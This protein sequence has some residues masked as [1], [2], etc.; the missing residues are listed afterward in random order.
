MKV[1]FGRLSLAWIA[2]RTPRA[3]PR[4]VAM[5]LITLL[6]ACESPEEKEARHYERGVELYEEGQDEKAMVEFQNVLRLNPKNAEAMYYFGLI[7][8]R[9]GRLEPAF[10]AFQQAS[11]E[12]TDFMAAQVKL[13]EAALALEN[14]E[15]ALKAA[16]TIAKREPDNPDALAIRASLALRDD[17]TKNAL[18]FANAALSKVPTHLNGIAVL[19][20]VYERLGELERA[21]ALL[22]QGLAAHPQNVGLRLLKIGLLEKSGDVDGLDTTYREIFTLKPEDVEYRLLLAQFYLR[23]DDLARAEAILRQ[24]IDEGLLDDSV[25][26]ALID[27]VY[28]RR[29]F[30][31]AEAELRNLLERMPQNYQLQFRLADLYAT[32]GQPD[33]AEQT[34][35]AIIEKAEPGETINDARAAIARI[36]LAKDDS[37]G[38][39]N[40][41]EEA[42]AASPDHPG[43]N[44]LKAVMLLDQGE[45]DEAARSVRAAL[46]RDPNWLAGLRLLAQVHLKRGETDAAVETLWKVLRLAPKDAGSAELL[47]YVL[48]QR[49]DYQTALKLWDH[50]TQIAPESA[51]ALQAR[52][53]IAIRLKNW[54]EAEA[55]IGWL[56]QMPGQEPIA[57]LLN[58]QLLLARGQIEEARA[59]LSKAEELQPDATEPMIGLVQSY[60]VTKDIAGALSYLEQRISEQPDDFPA[61]A[62]LSVILASQGKIDLARQAFDEATQVEST[63]PSSYREFG[64]VLYRTGDL[65]GAVEIYRAGLE[66]YQ[67][68]PS[69]LDGLAQLYFA[70]GRVDDAIETY[71]RLIDL[72]G[73]LDDAVVNNYAALV[74]DFRHADP[75]ALERALKLASRFRGADDADLLDTLGWLHYR[76]GDAAVA[77]TLLQRAVTIQPNEPQFRYHLGMALYHAGQ[78]DRALEELEYAVSDGARYQGIEEAQAMLEDLRKTRSGAV[79]RGESGG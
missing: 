17:D 9:G 57:W 21:L 66:R 25:T 79:S 49:G 8:Q 18:E 27:A 78:R 22:D 41:V 42:L 32:A 35:V 19:A 40:L 20:G 52:A 7:H 60:V 63:Q 11:I 59:A 5:L 37:E 74:A 53:A 73:S 76:Q 14:T 50:V 47:A 75:E 54:S 13:G 55:N 6:V 56:L 71:G 69:L 38:A 31:A 15:A 58:G 34:L 36:R 39:A 26:T 16:E 23:R 28:Q 64:R 68:D 72:G 10:V 45:L 2:T 1:L 48:T 77:R 43:A 61:L 12:R 62:S 46:R 24:A 51:R 70:S 44:L 65:A 4:V 3:W 30:E 29:G 67:D 33:Q